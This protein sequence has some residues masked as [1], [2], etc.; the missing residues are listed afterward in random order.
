MSIQM[1]GAAKYPA[2]ARPSKCYYIKKNVIIYYYIYSNI[3]I[4]KYSN[5][6]LRDLVNL[7]EEARADVLTPP[8][9]ER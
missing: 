1:F 7:V 5:R 3:Q 4:F 8:R 9:A 6:L 2:G